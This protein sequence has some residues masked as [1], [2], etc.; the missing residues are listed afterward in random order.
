MIYHIIKQIPWYE[1]NPDEYARIMD[2]VDTLRKELNLRSNTP[3][4]PIL[5]KWIITSW[6]EG[7]YV[8]HYN[9]EEQCELNKDQY[10]E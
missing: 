4:L 3:A 6:A 9:C 1:A 7:Y 2:I 5:E 10:E 8:G